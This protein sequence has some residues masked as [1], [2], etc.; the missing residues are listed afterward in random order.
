MNEKKFKVEIMVTHIEYVWAENETEAKE[1]AETKVFEEK[2]NYEKGELIT[3][4]KVKK[5]PKNFVL[6]N[7]YF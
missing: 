6:A 3:G 5:L 1:K 7:G 4:Y 2:V